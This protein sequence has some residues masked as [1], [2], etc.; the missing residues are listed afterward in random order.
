ML[1]AFEITLNM[2]QLFLLLSFLG[3]TLQ[4]FA[5]TKPIQQIQGRPN[6]I[7][8]LT[9]DQDY[10]DLGFQGNPEI[11][12]PNLD[13]LAS[14]SLEMG[15]FYVSSLCSPTRASILTGRSHQR[16]GILHTSRGATRLADDEI[17]IAEL[18]SK[19][20]YRTGIFGKWHLGD[21]YPSRPQDQGFEE[22]FYHKSGGIGQPPDGDGTYWN[23]VVHRNGKREV[24]ERYCTDLFFDK[25]IEYMNND[26]ERPY[27]IYLPTNVP[28][29]PFDVDPD[30]YQQ[31]V[32]FAS[33]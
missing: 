17:T 32:T 24:Y 13:Q 18:L 3:L 11:D 21:N 29:S 33:Y 25:A 26:D 30:Y 6:I 10:Y 5:Q 22:T 2:K 9:D 15:R 19:A 28:H 12:T 1:E 16:T 8:I 27:F 7:L 23:P 20:G 4:A 14:E 31:F